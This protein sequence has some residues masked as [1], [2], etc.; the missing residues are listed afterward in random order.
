LSW[1]YQIDR[2]AVGDRHRK[3]DPWC[4][5]DP[6]IDAFNLDPAA[7]GI[8]RHELDTVN[9][10]AERDGMKAGERAP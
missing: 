3:Q 9:L 1:G 8:E 10:I 6:P 7:T 2:D 4:R 5:S